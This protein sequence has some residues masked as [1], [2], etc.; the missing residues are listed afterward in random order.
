MNSFIKLL[1]LTNS[2]HE[3]GFKLPKWTADVFPHKLKEM[4]EKAF[5]Y[6]SFNDELKRL[7]G[8][9]FVKKAIEDW[10]KKITGE[11]EQKILLFSAHDITS[12]T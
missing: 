3:L 4:N 5:I 10:D 1:R 7:K 11:I 9:V 8:G 6:R 2:Q 12:I